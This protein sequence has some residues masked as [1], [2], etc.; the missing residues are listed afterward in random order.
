VTVIGII[1][2]DWGDTLMRDFRVCVAPMA[3]WPEVE[4]M[5]GAHTVL[6][7]LAPRY[8]LAVATNADESGEELVLEALARVDLR[9]FISFVVSSCEVGARKPE[10]AF[11]AAALARAGCVAAQAVMVGDSLINDV[12]GAAAAGLHTI[13]LDPGGDA[14]SPQGPRPDAVISSLTELPDALAALEHRG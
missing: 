3:T 12:G 9:R 4:A 1:F 13:W 5:P 11:F 8:R 14:P 6:R 10:S 7:Q 2:F